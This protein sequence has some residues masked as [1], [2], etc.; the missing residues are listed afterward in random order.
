M[1]RKPKMGT[2]STEPCE[3]CPGR[4]KPGRVTVD[5]R[6]GQVLVVIQDVPAGVCGRCGSKYFS[7]EVTGRLLRLARRKPKS[8]RSLKVPVVRFGSV[9]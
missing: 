8:S 7:D 4:V 5:L 9:A 1:L 6:R 2:R 3:Y